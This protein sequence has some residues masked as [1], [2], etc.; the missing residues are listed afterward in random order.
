M[1][2]KELFSAEFLLRESAKKNK[3][4]DFAVLFDCSCFCWQTCTGLL[5][6]AVINDCLKSWNAPDMLPLPPN[7]DSLCNDRE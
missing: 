1:R 5:P 3:Q 4:Q 2:T 7:L 6:L